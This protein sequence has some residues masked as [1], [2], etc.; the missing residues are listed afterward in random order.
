MVGGSAVV[1]LDD[2]ELV[3]LWIEHD[4]HRSFVVAMTHAGLLA[5]QPSYV[6]AAIIDIVDVNVEVD[7]SLADLRFGNALKGIER[8]LLGSFGNGRHDDPFCDESVGRQGKARAADDF[9]PRAE[10]GCS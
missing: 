2:A 4:H 6:A 1:V 5:A 7:A 3:A 10:C 9:C 8:E